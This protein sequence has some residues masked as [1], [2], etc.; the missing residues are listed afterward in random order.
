MAGSHS[1]INHKLLLNYIRDK[2]LPF[3]QINYVAA[4]F[5]V[6]VQF[7]LVWQMVQIMAKPIWQ[8]DSSRQEPTLLNIHSSTRILN[9]HNHISACIL[10]Q[11]YLVTYLLYL[12]L[13]LPYDLSRNPLKNIMAARAEAAMVCSCGIRITND[14]TNVI[15]ADITLSGIHALTAFEDLSSDGP[16]PN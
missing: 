6:K 15:A 2:P 10:F 13:P 1:S 4:L 9:S 14:I 7:P 11:N 8:Q 16:I 3:H 5:T 12:V